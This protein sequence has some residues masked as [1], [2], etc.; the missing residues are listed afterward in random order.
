MH[1]NFHC[2]GTSNCQDIDP[3]KSPLTDK[4]L[5]KCG[6]YTQGPI[7]QTSNIATEIMPVVPTSVDLGG[8]YTKRSQQQR[9]KI[10]DDVP[11]GKN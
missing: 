8:K 6:T 9:K 3:R 2:S 7:T 5:K 4:I 10:A 1:L 11:G